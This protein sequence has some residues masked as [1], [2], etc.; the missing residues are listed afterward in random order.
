MMRKDFCCKKEID[1]VILRISNGGLYQKL[2]D[3]EAF[4]RQL[5]HFNSTSYKEVGKSL[6]L[7][8]MSGIFYVLVLFHGLAFII[9]L[10]EVGHCRWIERHTN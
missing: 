5:K 9:F 6:G 1:T 7:E 3:D 10:M 4:F 8:E 2:V